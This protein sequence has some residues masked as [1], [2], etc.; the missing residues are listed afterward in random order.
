MMHSRI[1]TLVLVAFDCIASMS[2]FGAEQGTVRATASWQAEGEFFKVDEKLALFIGAFG[3]IMF[4]ETKKGAL[5]AA[6]L[7]CPALVEVNLDD[8]TQSGGGRCIIQAASGDRVY[9]RWTC[10]GEHGA[11]CKGPFTLLSGTGEFKGIT[12]QGEFQI[13]SD[14]A[15]YV[16][17]LP[18][19]S[20]KGKAAG[21]AMWPA[22]TYKIP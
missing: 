22:L 6:K 1:G 2:A 13:R 16:A 5:D 17:E 12:G 11:G 9:A 21:V 18:G 20:V 15:V 3:G 14:I 19:D 7:L 4:V 10:A 8:G